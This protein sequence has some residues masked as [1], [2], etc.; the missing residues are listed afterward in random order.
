MPS[1]TRHALVT[2][3]QAQALTEP[4]NEIRYKLSAKQKLV[5]RHPARFRVLVAGRRFGKSYM[6]VLLLLYEA[7]EEPDAIVWY[8]APTY[9]QG[10]EILWK[11]LKK[12]VPLE[13]VYTLN[14]T[15]LSMQLRNGSVIAIKGSDNPDSLRGV[16]LRFAALDEYAYQEA[17]TWFE[18]VRPM[19]AIGGGRSLF[20][21]TPNGLNWAYDLYLMGTG[22][23]DEFQSWQFTTLEGGLV[24]QKEIDH[25]RRH[26]SLRQFKQE[27]EA[28]FETLS[29]RVYS[30]FERGVHL[31][32]MADPGG[33]LLVGLDFNVNPMTAVI[34]VSVGPT[35]LYVMD[36]L[37]I[38]S[39]NTQ[40]VVDELKARYPN[41]PIFV[42]PDPSGKAR[43]TASSSTNFTILEEA[44]FTV[45]VPAK[46]P[47]IADRVNAVQA[48]L[49][50]AN[51]DVH[52]W[53]H[54]R[55]T[56]LV[57]SFD[58]QQYK[59][60]TS[61]PDKTGG[62]DHAA[63]AVG[64]LVWQQFNLLRGAWKETSVRY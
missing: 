46:A 28:S 60:G 35:D 51:G 7:L 61:I 45:D 14:E 48:M 52:L 50:T 6:A 33:E 49:R 40:E 11:M 57:R 54:P 55:A 24:P 8:I 18:V 23:D 13:Y 31:R 2:T 30:N 22:K 17:D 29:G 26:M 47:A 9:R 19:L 16:G 1:S 53:V 59:Q 4:R 12:L 34:G 42:C 43:T 38:M 39:S 15:D 44:G 3:A 62:L 63:D 58:G 27:F 36:A 25:A 37:E 10:K 20:I 32:E 5:F 64:Y 21:T 56:A 41:R